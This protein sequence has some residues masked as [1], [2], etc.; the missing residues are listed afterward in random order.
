LSVGLQAVSE[1]LFT[2][3]NSQVNALPITWLNDLIARV[4]YN[5][6]KLLSQRRSAG[7]PYAFLYVATTRVVC[8]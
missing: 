7:L 6:K 1:I 4:L 2:S 5:S 3:K 8:V